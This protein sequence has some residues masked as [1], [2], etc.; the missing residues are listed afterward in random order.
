MIKYIIPFILIT[1]IG[2]ESKR[3]SDHTY[4]G[5]KIINP[6]GKYVL[7]SDYDGFSDTIKLKDDNS[8]SK[9][10][11]SLKEGVYYFKHGNEHQFV[12]IQPN[13]SIL[14]RLNT[15]A[16][17]ESLV[18]GGTSLAASRN[19]IL[20]ET[21]LENE[22]EAKI[23]RKISK[24]PVTEFKTKVDSLLAT[25]SIKLNDYVYDNAENSERFLNLFNI[26]LT[27]QAY[28]EFENYATDN[29]I[30]KNQQEL[31]SNYYAYRDSISTSLD[32]LMLFQPYS[33]Y[34][35]AN[36]YNKVYS[37][38]LKNNTESFTM[39]LLS[40]IDK[41]IADEEVKNRLL[42]NTTVKHFFS[43]SC[44]YNNKKV[45][46]TFFKLSS[47]IEDKK[48]I[49]R[50][51]NDTKALKDG[52]DLPSFS[53]LD[54]TGE[55][56]DIKDLVK[57]KKTVI[58]FRTH[59]YSSNDWVA[60]RINYFSKKNPDV[61]FLVVSSCEKPRCFTKKIPISKQLNLPADSKARDFLTSNF[62]RLI[63]I[64]EKGK[65]ANSFSSLSSNK[66]NQQL[67]KH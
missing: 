45:L 59:K 50:L 4:F 63:I 67:Q 49:Q 30:D 9:K 15:W 35:I 57:N 29:I 42:F 51:I 2:C 43:E 24:L 54:A 11:N 38:G 27:H 14:F 3:K 16:F 61:N 19:N 22:R 7:L 65:V 64:D 36:L 44:H 62:S 60:S 34:V 18:F 8:F 46:F 25:K 17:D 48:E 20:I 56:H 39:E 52:Q 37:K 31:P 33:E 1:L 5:G 23:L 41:T 10:Y 40:D 32:S 28:A 58:Y 13:D 12:Y 55:M 47:S 21:F 6:K 26:A 66:L 53:I